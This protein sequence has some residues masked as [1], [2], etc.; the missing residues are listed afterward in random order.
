[1]S[2]IRSYSNRSFLSIG[3]E[4]ETT[5]PATDE[6]SFAATEDTPES[7]PRGAFPVNKSRETTPSSG[8]DIQSFSVDVSSVT[9]KRK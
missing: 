5:K 6:S 7:D 9:V 8:E 4:A 2:C 1:M 3:A